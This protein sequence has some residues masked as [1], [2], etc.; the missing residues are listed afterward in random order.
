MHALQD[1]HSHR[2]TSFFIEDIL[3]KPKPVAA[4]SPGS[5]TGGSPPGAAGSLGAGGVG[6]LAA[7]GAG[8]LFTRP[9]PASTTSSPDHLTSASAAAHVV[10]GLSAV[11]GLQAGNKIILSEGSKWRKW[12]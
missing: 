9:S 8:S 4:G 3:L 2:P 12:H 6:S 5:L 11:A 1:H 10:A 7:A